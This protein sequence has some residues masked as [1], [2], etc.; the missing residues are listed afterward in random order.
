MSDPNPLDPLTRYREIERA[1]RNY[2]ES[3]GHKWQ[4]GI[5]DTPY[6]SCSCGWGPLMEILESTPDPDI[7]LVPVRRIRTEKGEPSCSSGDRCP[8]LD[9]GASRYGEHE[10][11]CKFLPNSPEL[12]REYTPSRVIPHPDCP[13]WRE[14]G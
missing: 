3:E 13:V 9:I 1:A 5:F 12:V 11:Q 2:S 14:E 6:K 7:A 8:Y 4:C 10:D